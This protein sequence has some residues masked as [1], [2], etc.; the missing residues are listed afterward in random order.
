MYF[1]STKSA[2]IL[3]LCLIMLISSKLPGSI[4]S[5]DDDWEEK[6]KLFIWGGLA[7]SPDGEMVAVGTSRGI[8]LHTSD[9]L[10]IIEDFAEECAVSS[11]DWSPDGSRIVS[12]CSNGDMYIWNV[13]VGQWLHHLPKHEYRSTVASVAWSP[14]DDFIASASWDGNAYVWEAEVGQLM[15]T[16][17]LH[18]GTGSAFPYSLSWN[19][20]GSQIAVQGRGRIFIWDVRAERFSLSVQYGRA[21]YGLKWSPNGETL[22]HGELEG[23]I[24]LWDAI[25]GELQETLEVGGRVIS[26]GWSPD[27][28]QL[29]THIASASDVREG[30]IQ[31]WDVAIDEVVAELPNVIMTGD[32]HYSNALEW[33]PDGTRL[34]SISDDGR[35]I[36]WDMDTY[37][38]I[39]VYDGYQSLVL[40]D[41]G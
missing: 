27:S 35:V 30:Q 2:R 36:I 3:F 39:A 17:D 29:A 23:I 20:N 38:E 5:Q 18:T 1:I 15:Q 8:R 7:W 34:A 24:Q 21:I 22:V 32:G 13:E 14:S 37:E 12:G 10:S 4:V 33:S 28:T 16:I 9:D 11:L 41:E 19:L 6:P 31:V 26:L 25:N 40:A